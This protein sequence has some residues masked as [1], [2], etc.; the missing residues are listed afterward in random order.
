MLTVWEGNF[1]PRH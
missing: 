1:C